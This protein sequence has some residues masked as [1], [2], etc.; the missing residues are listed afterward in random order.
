MFSP[1]RPTDDDVIHRSRRTYVDGSELEPDGMTLL[2]GCL[3]MADKARPSDPADF[4]L[5]GTNAYHA[6][7]Q[8][9]SAMRLAGHPS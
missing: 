9:I 8:A 3:M 6:D 1:F 4:A 7:L 2:T 5:R